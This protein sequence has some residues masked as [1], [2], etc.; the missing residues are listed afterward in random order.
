MNKT[1]P[2]LF[3]GEVGDSLKQGEG[4]K[5]QPADSRKETAVLEIPDG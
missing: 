2:E 1:L 3:V 5:E 4:A